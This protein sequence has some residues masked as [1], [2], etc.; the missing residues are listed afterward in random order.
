MA[1]ERYN[2]EHYAANGLM[3]KIVKKTTIVKSDVQERDE[4]ESNEAKIQVSDSSSSSSE[5]QDTTQEVK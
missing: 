4:E 1:V 3:P 2:R 5:E